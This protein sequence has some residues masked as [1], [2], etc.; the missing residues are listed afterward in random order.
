MM[1]FWPR[2]S[3]VILILA[4]YILCSSLTSLQATSLSLDSL[5]L[6]LRGPDICFGHPQVLHHVA[7]ALTSIKGI[8]FE[9]KSGSEFCDHSR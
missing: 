3:V 7:A 2:R 9:T 6:H 4:A 1:Q 8:L 5:A